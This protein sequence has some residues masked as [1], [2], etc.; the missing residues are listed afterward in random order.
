[1]VYA[2]GISTAMVRFLREWAEDKGEERRG[3][4][5]D[6]AGVRATMFLREKRKRKGGPVQ[7]DEVWESRADRMLG[8]RKTHSAQRR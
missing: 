4:P 1:M 7:G 8:K 5:L 3:G 2:V 6:E